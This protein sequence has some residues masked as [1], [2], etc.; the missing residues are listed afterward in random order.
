MASLP[1]PSL[2]RRELYRKLE[3]RNQELE[4]ALDEIKTLRGILPICANCKKIRDDQG[5]W[6]QI[7]QYISEHSQAEFSHGLCPECI[8]ELYPEL[9]DEILAKHKNKP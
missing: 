1:T 5:Y 8:R 7:E 2:T 6:N 9:A 3:E 4:K